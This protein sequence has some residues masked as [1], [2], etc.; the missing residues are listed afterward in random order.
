MFI[1]GYLFR[2]RLPIEQPLQDRVGIQALG[3]GMEIQQNAMAQDGSSQ[4]SDIFVGD[5]IPATQQSA[6]FGGQ[7]NELRGAH[8][9]AE[10]HVAL[11]EIRS[12]SV[13]G[14]RG[15]DQ[16][17]RIAR[18]RVGDRHHADQLLERQNLRGIGDRVGLRGRA[19]WW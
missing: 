19:S 17:H 5:V 7:H 3:F 16:F 14:T 13:V 10:I 9:S 18:D 2:L 8:A 11:H 6:G 12:A 15:T 1:R 4:G